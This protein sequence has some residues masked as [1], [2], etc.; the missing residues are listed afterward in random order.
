MDTRVPRNVNNANARRDKV[1][2]LTDSRYN[3]VHYKYYFEYNSISIGM[4]LSK[5]K[6]EITNI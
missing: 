4:L 2:N 5:K 1:N 3:V 6:T